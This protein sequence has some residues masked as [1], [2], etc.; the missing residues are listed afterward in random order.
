MEAENAHSNFGLFRRNPKKN[1]KK[2]VQ[3]SPVGG[4]NPFGKIL[5]KLDHFQGR[6]ENKKF[7]SCHHL[8]LDDTFGMKN[9]TSNK[10]PSAPKNCSQRPTNKHDRHDKDMTSILG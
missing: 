9:V 1:T 10:L 8:V 5:A 2:Q 4:F 6:G 3:N 7:L